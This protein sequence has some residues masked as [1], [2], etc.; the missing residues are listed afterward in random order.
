MFTI[1][2]PYNLPSLRKVFSEFNPAREHRDIIG[3]NNNIWFLHR[4]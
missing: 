2:E 4:E 3:R 1:E